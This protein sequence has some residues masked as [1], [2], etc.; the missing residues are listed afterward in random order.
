ML[1]YR[2]LLSKD[3][4]RLGKWFVQPFE[5]PEK[6]LQK[7]SH[8][9]FSFQYF[10]HG[11]SFI[12]A[13]VDVR[14]HPAVRRLGPQHLASARAGSNSVQA[15]L[16]P[17][18][19]AATLTGVT[20][21]SQDVSQRLNDWNTFYPLDRNR[22]ACPDSS[23]DVITMPPAV[24]VIVAGVKMVYPTCYV[25]VT[26]FDASPHNY[27][28]NASKHRNSAADNFTLNAEPTPF[29]TSNHPL[30]S[31]NSLSDLQSMMPM[32]SLMTDQAWHD[33]LTV[34]PENPES[35]SEQQQHQYHQSHN[36]SAGKACLYII[37]NF[38]FSYKNFKCPV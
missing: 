6:T 12:C 9:S 8:L 11:E 21:K 20:Y 16:A 30:L 1:V 26:D 19:L 4:V 29:T 31:E 2:N 35:A 28:Q 23:G 18:G 15:I 34:N 38:E 37:A 3:F 24:E 17:F 7:A 5:G 13:S 22:Y 36:T 27:N 10:V 33:G 25:L 32:S 14:Q